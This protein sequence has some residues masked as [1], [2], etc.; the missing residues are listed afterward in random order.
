MLL[1]VSEYFYDNEGDSSFSD[2]LNSVRN[3][4]SFSFISD[5]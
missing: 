4:V 2:E 5:I 1:L 3:S